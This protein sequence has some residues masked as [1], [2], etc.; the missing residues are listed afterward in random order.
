MIRTVLSKIRRWYT[1]GISSDS[2]GR[3]IVSI[4]IKQV[5]LPEGTRGGEER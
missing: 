5:E 4:Y 2:K 1:L 3:P